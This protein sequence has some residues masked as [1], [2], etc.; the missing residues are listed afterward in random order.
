MKDKFINSSINFIQ[1]Y[2]EC[3]DLK[4][5]KLK[6]G[7][8]GIYSLLVKISVVI[9]ISIFTKTITETLLPKFDSCVLS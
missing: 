5:K 8:E 3:D 1:K 6:Y 7:L 2:Q 4:L 9:I